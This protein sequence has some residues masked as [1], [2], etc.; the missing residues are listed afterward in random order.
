[1]PR[2]IGVQLGQRQ[3]LGCEGGR[4]KQSRIELTSPPANV[5]FHARNGTFNLLAVTAAHTDAAVQRL[6]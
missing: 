5:R 2:D 1:M 3:R 6:G 4:S